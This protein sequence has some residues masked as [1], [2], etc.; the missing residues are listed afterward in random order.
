MEKSGVS[1]SGVVDVLEN[2]LP[3]ATREQPME[4]RM[5]ITSEALPNFISGCTLQIRRYQRT[6]A[7][8]GFSFPSGSF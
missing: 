3:M 8:P 2:L 1:G 4:T 5:A 6:M 7:S